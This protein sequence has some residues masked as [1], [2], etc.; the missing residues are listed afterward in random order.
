MIEFADIER[1]TYLLYISRYSVVFANSI[2]QT[3]NN[4]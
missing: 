2:Q 4:Q 3:F 1:Y